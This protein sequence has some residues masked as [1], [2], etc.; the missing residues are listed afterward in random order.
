[1]TAE[2]IY[3]RD[4][5]DK[6]I[7][8]TSIDDPKAIAYARADLAEHL[9]VQEKRDMFLDGDEHE[10]DFRSPCDT[11]QHHHTDELNYPCAACIH[12]LIISRHPNEGA[13]KP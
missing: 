10:P 13:Y 3:I 9:W 8:L 7:E 6:G 12:G 5:G 1:M 4:N 11:C 2:L